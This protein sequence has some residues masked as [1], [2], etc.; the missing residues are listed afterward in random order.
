MATRIVYSDDSKP[1]ITR[2][3][4]RNGWAYYDAG[5]DRITDRD[6]ID[7]LNAIGLPPAY[8]DAWFNPRANG[9]IQAVGWD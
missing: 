4:V 6:E 1:G 7:R 2:R 3:K 8:R 5:G 9:H